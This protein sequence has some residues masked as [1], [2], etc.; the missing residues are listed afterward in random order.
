MKTETAFFLRK[1]PASN[2]A[3]AGIIM[4]T[5]APARII[6][7]VSPVSS[8]NENTILSYYINLQQIIVKQDFKKNFYLID[9]KQ[10]P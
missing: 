9:D 10:N 2:N 7:V 4:N 5:N 1:R 3:S 6:Q 8:P